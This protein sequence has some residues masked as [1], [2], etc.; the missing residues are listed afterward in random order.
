MAWVI[1]IMSE[2]NKDVLKK[3]INGF[4]R[5]KYLKSPKTNCYEYY[6]QSTINKVYNLPH[7]VI[8]NAS[9][10]DGNKLLRIDY[11]ANIKKSRSKQSK[12]S[13]PKALTN[14]EINKLLNVIRENEMIYIWVLIMLYSGVRPSE[15]LA[16]KWSDIN[17]REK[18]I[19]IS[20]TLSQEDFYDANH[21]AKTRPSIPIITI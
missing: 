15:A 21:L 3:F 6:S 14:D 12:K 5:K 13:E 17:Y 4:S 1:S 2:I 10:E 20:R 18:K 19:E 16:L 9:S 7:E 8:K 11:I